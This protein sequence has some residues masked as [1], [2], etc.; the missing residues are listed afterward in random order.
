VIDIHTFML[1]LGVGNMA[2]ALLMAGYLRNAT[3]GPGLVT[4]MW[5][6][7]LSGLVQT[8]SWLAAQSGAGIDIDVA[9]FAWVGGAALEVAA[10]CQFFGFAGSAWQRTLFP[11]AA[12]ALAAVGCAV[13]ADVSQVQMIR[14]MGISIAVFSTGAAGILLRPK[15]KAS[16]LQ[17]LIGVNDVLFAV[18]IV[19][20][21]GMTDGGSGASHASIIL[22]LA[23]LASY[24]LMIVNG[25]GFLL[26]CKQK[27]DDRMRRLATIDGLTD[28]LNRHAFFEQ[29]ESARRLALR[30]DKPVALLMLD[31]DHFKQLND[32]HGHACG[33]EALRLFAAAV[34]PQLRE[35]DLMGRLGGEEF[36]L[37]LPG[38]N[39]DGAQLVA[40]RVRVA[41]HD[42]VLP[43]QVGKYRM[44]VS[45]GLVVLD[46]DEQLTS[47]LGRADHALYAAKTGGRNRV[48]VGQ[49]DGLL[50]RA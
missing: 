50:K 16:L 4:W 48:V 29:A 36:A 13:A 32:N 37:L 12:L 18:A 10:Y 17:R 3:S 35:H 20:W 33:D 42:T 47:A 40:E 27:D 8:G 46:A 39:I 23:Y 5:A 19:A 15:Q 1:A 11:V 7:L 14:V 38:T 30:H 28:T 43:A 41:V 31:L 44:T 21:A 49:P 2:F 26:L 45:I 25:F 9:A 24:L 6:R 34:R 22:G